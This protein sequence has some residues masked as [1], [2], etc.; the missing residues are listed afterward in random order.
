MILPQQG[1][2]DPPSGGGPHLCLSRFEDEDLDLAVRR[3]LAVLREAAAESSAGFERPV[4]PGTV[5]RPFV[6]RYSALS[7]G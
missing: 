7:I 3:S 5:N 1:L 2:A 6:R 4:G